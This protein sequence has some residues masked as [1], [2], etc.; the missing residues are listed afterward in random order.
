MKLK[1]IAKS[2]RGVFVGHNEEYDYV[3]L[4]LD[5]I[6]DIDL[7]DLLS[8]ETWDDQG[9]LFRSVKNLTKKETIRICIENWS[10]SR[11][12]AFEFLGRLNNP[13]KITH[14]ET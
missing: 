12:V 10:C 11:D 3:V 8:S 13:T 4:S 9:G 5:D 2:D 7:S 1:I 14:I 6:K